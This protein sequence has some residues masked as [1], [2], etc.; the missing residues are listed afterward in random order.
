MRVGRANIAR[1]G[2]QIAFGANEH[3][4]G[5]AGCDGCGG[6]VGRVV[7][8]DD[9]GPSS[10]Q[11]M[12]G[13]KRI[14]P[15]TA[16][17]TRRHDDCHPSFRSHL[18]RPVLMSSRWSKHIACHRAC[19]HAP[20]D[21]RPHMAESGVNENKK[22]A[23]TRWHPPPHRI[24]PGGYTESSDLCPVSW[25]PFFSFPRIVSMWPE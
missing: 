15:L 3:D 10:R 9:N 4:R 19:R 20:P 24:L 2:A 6:I 22:M 14:H 21:A 8:N 5:K 25:P 17:V 7:V 11:I 23:T 1:R 13:G 16:P 12:Q 18:T